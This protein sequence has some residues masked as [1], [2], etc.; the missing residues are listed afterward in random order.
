[1]KLK[2][3]VEGMTCASCQAHVSKAVEQLEGTSKVNVNLLKNTLDVEV[4]EAKCDA[5]KIEDAVQKAGYKAYIPNANKKTDKLIEKNH[6][7]AYLIFSLVDLLVIMYFSMGH[8]MW[9]WPVPK[10]FNMHTNPMGFSLV[11]FILV[12]PIIFLYRKYFINGFKKL[13]KL[14]PNMDTLIAIGATFSI[15]YGIYCLFMISMGYTEYHMY[16][17][18]EAAGMILTLVSLGKYLEK[19]SK[20]KNDFLPFRHRQK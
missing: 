4:D 5:S 3:N 11:Q 19:L 15:A 2:F 6:D 12:L 10:V 8:M 7:L 1:M 16:L 13:I 18:F 20:R 17:Y 14:S 9:G